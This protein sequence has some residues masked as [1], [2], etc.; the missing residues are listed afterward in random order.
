MRLRVCLLTEIKRYKSAIRFRIR[1]TK[2]AFG[3]AD[4]YTELISKFS[5]NKVEYNIQGRHMSHME[6]YERTCL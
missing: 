4:I 3:S 1:I 2:F 6:F 5:Q